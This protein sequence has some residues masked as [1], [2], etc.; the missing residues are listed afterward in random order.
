MN[1]QITLDHLEQLKLDGMLQAY[2]AVLALPVQSQRKPS[3]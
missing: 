3:V 1:K 2:Q